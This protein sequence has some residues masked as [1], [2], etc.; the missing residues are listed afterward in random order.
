MQKHHDG[1]KIY[2]FVFANQSD[3]DEI[4]KI[5]D[6]FSLYHGCLKKNVNFIRVGVLFIE[7]AGST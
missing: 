6:T 5:S 3:M 2:R 7:I 4:F 1:K